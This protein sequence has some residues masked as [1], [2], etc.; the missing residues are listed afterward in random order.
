MLGALIIASS[1]ALAAGESAADPTNYQR[2]VIGER[3]LGMGGAQTA[4]V[5]DPMANLYNPAAMVFITSSMVSASKALY[6]LDYRKVEG[7]FVP[8]IAAAS[9]DPVNALAL[10][11]ENDLSLPS[12]LSIVAPFGK[13]LYKRGPKRHAFGI[14]IL[15]PLQDS[16]TYR[17]KWKAEADIRDAETYALS[18]S[19]TQV[20]TGVS[21]AARLSESFGLGASAF[22]V[23]SSWSRKLSQSRFGDEPECPLM[24]D[25]CGFMQFWDSHVDIDVISLLFRIGALWQPH[26]NWRMGLVVSAPTILLPNVVLYKTQGKLDQTFGAANVGGDENDFAWYFT[27]D[28]K[29]KVHGIE[30]MNFRAGVGYIWHDI[31]AA[32]ID[33]TFHLPISYDR[34][35]GDPVAKRRFPEDGPEDLSASPDWFDIGVIR[36]IERKPVLNFNIGW[37]Y[38]ID[39]TWTIRNGFFTDFSSAPDVKPTNEP[40]LWHINRYGATVAAGFKHEGYDVSVGFMGAFGRGQASVFN[41]TVDPLVAWQPAPLEERALYIFIAGVQSAASKGAKQLYKKAKEGEL[42]APEEDKTEEAE[43][44]AAG[45]EAA[46]DEAAAEEVGGDEAA[47]ETEEGTAE[48]AAEGEGAE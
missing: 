43:Q 18:E 4:V 46:G 30:P 32:D 34:I 15:V 7:G 35:K 5:N 23:R 20:W 40:Q 29:L 1:V 37:E 44:G 9:G 19:N 42:F 41:D 24:A 14:A 11:H 28:Y 12:T 27:D 3:A 31:F 16:Y 6:S 13:R 48:T 39:A 2:Y 22:L 25:E 17:A 36:E 45:D 33:V 26:E 38:I 10:E 8:S 47:E 21:Y